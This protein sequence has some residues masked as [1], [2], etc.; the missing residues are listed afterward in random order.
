M[1]QNFFIGIL[2]IMIAGVFV[3]LFT[4]P[5]AK[6][7]G[8]K[9]ENI[10][11]LGSLLALLL[12]PWP[13]TFSTVNNVFSVYD[14]IDTFTIVITLLFGV[15][16]GI[17]SIYWG[18]GISAVGM[19]LGVTLAIGFVTLFGS[20]IP[21]II[22]EPGELLTAGGIA[23][24]ISITIMI[25][26][27]M[28]VSIAGQQKEKETAGNMGLK[29]PSNKV[30]FLLGFFFCMISGILS[31]MVNIGF[32]FGAPIG[33]VAQSTGTPIWASGFAIWAWVFT[34]N[35]A[36]NLIYAI[37]LTIKNN[38][39]HHYLKNSKP[40]YWL[41]G[42][43]M[44]ITW[45]GAMVIY[46]IAAGMLGDFGAYVGFPMMLLFSIVAGNVAGVFLGEWKGTKIK[47]R[48]TMLIGVFVLVLAFTFLGYSNKL[49][50]LN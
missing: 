14:E 22:F 21:M 8:W 38:S 19:A 17:G 26:G 11:G 33:E 10:W 9:F 48:R 37:I 23:L 30:P 35:F 12:I 20:I 44:G 25:V 27:V 24:I 15:G 36:V 41:W 49:L 45:P 16:W 34:G 50:I 46:G 3:G 31:A 47:S 7:P 13:L 28:I 2:L 43:F 29:N 40:S 18:K 39:F 1:I 42:L 4:L 5:L 6:T 32:I